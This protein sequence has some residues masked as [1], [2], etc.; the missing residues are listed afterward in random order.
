MT[1]SL[2]TKPQR[3]KHMYEISQPLGQF[4]AAIFLYPH[5][6]DIRLC[7]NVFDHYCLENAF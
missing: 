4:S 6:L 7:R 5:R 3:C 2:T 1:N